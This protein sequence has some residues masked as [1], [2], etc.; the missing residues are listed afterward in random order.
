MNRLALL[1]I[2]I[3]MS[4]GAIRADL[5]FRQHRYDSFRA[6][7][8]NEQSI[9][10][11]GNSITNMH[12]WWEAFG[13]D[14]RVANRG[15]SGA[16]TPELIANVGSITA[17]KPAK[18]FI[19]IGTNDL[20]TG[21]IS[22][23]DS[24]AQRI[25][26]I[27][28]AIRRDSPRTQVYVQ[29]ILPSNV[30]IRNVKATRA[31]NERVRELVE[32]MGATFID[33]FDEM[34]PI[35]EKEISY[36]GLHLTSKGY[37]KWLRRIA[38]YVEI[39]P[40]YSDMLTENNGGISSNSFGM[41]NTYFSA[42]PVDRDDILIMGDEMIHGGEWHELL[43]NPRIKNRG[44]GWGFGGLRLKQWPG[45]V[46]AILG[47]NGN[48]Q[49]PRKI[50]LYLGTADMLQKGAD[51]DSI[52]ADYRRVIDRIRYYAPASQTEIGI[53]SITPLPA[54]ERNKNIVAPLNEKL[55]SLAA[56]LPGT[57]YIDIFTPLSMADGRANSRYVDSNGYITGYGYGE[58][59]RTL[60]PEIPGAD[61]L[62]ADEIERN[63]A[64]T[65]A[66]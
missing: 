50:M 60:A 30:G 20:G 65:A 27:V 26:T 56:T 11:Y 42:Y 23:P 5:P 54:E 28:S 8:L 48:K 13:C 33:L 25:A 22:Q 55:R 10:F 38:P 44:T 19:G 2:L 12:E 1:L 14:E 59:A 66:N 18:V 49:A 40:I 61:P 21:S 34:M 3:A 9:V 17:G 58:I 51:Q 36:D 35:T 16:I 45:A 53:M 47:S 62:S 64:R 52:I 57:T 29:S 41:R 32:P 63:Y 24:V 7:P 37:T 15:N 46:D 4:A 31:T 39:E 6:L 43:R